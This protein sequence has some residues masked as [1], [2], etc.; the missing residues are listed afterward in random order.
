MLQLWGDVQRGSSLAAVI[1]DNH[2]EIA[3]V[4]MT[5]DDAAVEELQKSKFIDFYQRNEIATGDCIPDLYAIAD[6]YETLTHF[7]GSG[8]AASAIPSGICQFV[9]CPKSDEDTFVASIPGTFKSPWDTGTSHTFARWI[10][11]DLLHRPGLLYDALEVATLLGLKLQGLPLIEK[12][13]EKCRYSGIFASSHGPRWWVSLVRDEIRKLTKAN[14][15]QPL[16]ELGRTLAGGDKHKALFSKCHGRPNSSEAPTVVAFSD[17]T[18]RTRVQAAMAD[19]IPV[20]TDSSSSGFEQT[21]Q[22]VRS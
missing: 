11:N 1:H 17:G 14:M 3:L 6:G 8:K 19:T 5:G 2:P 12:H 10:W 7:F 13:L 20:E 18:K 21:R 9:K 16:W 15:S 4:G 22:Y